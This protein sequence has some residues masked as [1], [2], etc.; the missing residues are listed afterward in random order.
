VLS[1]LL[2]FLLDADGGRPPRLAEGGRTEE[3]R[4][5][6]LVNLPSLTKGLKQLKM[7]AEGGVGIDEKEMGIVDLPKPAVTL[8]GNALLPAVVVLSLKLPPGADDDEFGG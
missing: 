7:L 6:H 1:L 8:A 4:V 5:C 2:L 3:V